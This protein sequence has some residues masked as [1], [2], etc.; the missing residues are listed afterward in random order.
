MRRGQPAGTTRSARLQESAD[1]AVEGSGS[2]ALPLGLSGRS[3]PEAG[4]GGAAAPAGTGETGGTEPAAGVGAGEATAAMV[5]AAD[6]AVAGQD[7]SQPAGDARVP[8][9]DLP[10]PVRAGPGQPAGGAARPGAL[11]SG[12]A[13]AAPRGAGR[14]GRASRPGCGLPHLRPPGRGRRPGRART[15]GGRPDHRR[16]RTAPRSSPWSSGAPATSCS[17]RCPTAH[18]PSTSSSVWPTLIGR[19][20]GPAA[21]HPDLGPG[22]R[23]GRP[24]HVHRRPPA[25]RSTSATR[26]R[27]GSAAATRTPTACCASTSPRAPTF[28]TT[29]QADLD[30]VADQLNGR[31]RKTLDW[32]TPSEALADYLLATAAA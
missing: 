18:R 27:P 30:A 14:G 16:P 21:A 2:A 20:P 32:Q 10:G 9:D 1:V 29:T 23:D 13:R 11:R 17:G 8:R 22:H 19:L 12:R 15:L 28:R 6:R 31:P 7:V 26:T 25:A 4:G 3:G 5:A 24:R